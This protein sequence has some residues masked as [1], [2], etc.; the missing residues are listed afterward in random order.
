M[1]CYCV[2]NPWR[3]THAKKGPIFALRRRAA[4]EPGVVGGCALKT[5]AHRAG[6]IL[7]A[8]E[9]WLGAKRGVYQPLALVNSACMA[10]LTFSILT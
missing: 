5:P 9:G 10:T 7:C 2:K 4:V 6:V 1:R 8:G 3:V